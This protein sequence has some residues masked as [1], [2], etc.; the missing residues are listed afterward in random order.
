[1]SVKKKI[2]RVFLAVLL[3]CA[4]AAAGGYGY[5]WYLNNHFFV[6]GAAYPIN[7]E[8]L[9]LRGEEIS[10]EHYNAVRAQLPECH[11]LWDVP[12]QNSR[13]PSDSSTLQ[14]SGL[15][16]EDMDVL[17]TYFPQLNTLDA[18]GCGEYARLEE[19]QAL[20]PECR[21]IYNV[22]LGGTAVDHEAKEVTLNHGEC[23]YDTLTANLKHL[24][25]LE[26]L[27][28]RKTELSLEQ[29][30]QLEADYDQVNVSY[31]VEV[32]GREYDWDT[33]ELDLS[34][35]TSEQVDVTAEKLTM[36]PHLTIVEL[37]D[38]QGVLHLSWEEIQCLQVS[39][40]N[41]FFH[42]TVEVLGREYDTQTRELDLSD[43]TSENV[44]AVAQKLAMLP[45]LVYVELADDSGTSQLTREEVKRL[46]QAAPDASFHYVFDFYGERIST[47]DS[48]VYIQDKNIGDEHIEEVR[49]ALDVMDSS[50][51]RFVLDNC[52]ISNEL[53]AQLREEYRDTTK[54]VWRVAFG[55]GSALTDAE[56][57][58]CAFDLVD[59]NSANLYY[60]EDARFLDIGHNEWLDS[61]DFVAGMKSLEYVIVSGAP[62]RDLTPFSNCKNLKFLELAFCGY[63][64]DL[65]PLAA[66][67]K[68][69]MLN[70]SNTQVRDLSPLDELPMTHLCARLN[71]GGGSRVSGKEQ[72]RFQEQHPDCWATFTGS[73]PY[74]SG[75]RYDKDQITPLPQ[76]ALLQQVFRYH[77][78]P[79]PNN[80]GWY[81]EE[82][83][84]EIEA[85][86]EA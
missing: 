74:G 65:T 78:T 44:D 8:Q 7:A 24:P 75:W 40:S 84:A 16:Q 27:T 33:G 18:T 73:Q 59:D 69:Q 13:Y 11:I 71:P 22:D 49:L 66:C 55:E 60:C 25:D 10:F 53:L 2:L 32:L 83:E 36:L 37:M 5:A 80:G 38:S 81:L 26:Q 30:R 41:A 3:I 56:I 17:L 4:L 35:L 45:N 68:L 42:F 51:Q 48:Q 64:K 1:M 15:S 79:P 72:K 6:E 58:R 39:A 43:L 63:V 14:I 46:K 61:V 77:I 23:D 28:L 62:I 52:G 76:Y 85:E 20:R 19:F 50:C 34:D 9:D 57:I 70:I 29:I 21:V 31:T 54:V 86:V 12:F 47:T 82:I 67:K